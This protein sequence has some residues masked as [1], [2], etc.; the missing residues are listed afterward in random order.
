MRQTAREENV[1][2]ID[3][4]A[5]SKLLYEALGIEGSGALFKSGD[6]THH[7]KYGS[8]ELAK[9]VVEGIK[10]NKLGLVKYLATDALP[11]DPRRPDPLARFDVPASPLTTNVKPLGN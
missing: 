10:A 8:Y 3:L 9:C 7:S 1:A 11:F 6:G 2:L 4:H 5:M